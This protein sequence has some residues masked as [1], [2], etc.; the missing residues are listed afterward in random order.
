MAFIRLV[1]FCILLVSYCYDAQADSICETPI[2]YEVIKDDNLQEGFLWMGGDKRYAIYVRGDDFIVEFKKKHELKLIDGSAYSNKQ[3]G[4]V[5]IDSLA[6]RNVVDNEDKE[7]LV[8][9]ST[10]SFSTQ[11][12]AKSRHL[13]IIDI[14]RWRTIINIG[15]YDSKFFKDENGKEQELVYQ[16]DIFISH[17]HIK[18]EAEEDADTDLAANELDSGIYHRRGH[19]YVLQPHHHIRP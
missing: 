8:Y 16:A 9:Y 4:E 3:D 1:F 15:L 11:G 18:I 19:C 7:L 13:L 5:Y 12:G 6:L 2:H 14:H 17:N 10:F